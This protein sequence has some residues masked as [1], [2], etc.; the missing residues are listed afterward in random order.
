M[1]PPTPPNVLFIFPDQLRRYSAGYWSKPPF[2]PHV[3]GRPDPVVTPNIDLLAEQ[4]VVFTQAVANYPICSPY[5]GML[6]TGAYPATNG[7]W[8]NCFDGREHGLNT[9]V[10]CLPQIFKDAGYQTS[11][12][13]KCHWVKTEALFDQDHNYVGSTSEPGGHLPNRYDTY[14]PP[15]PSRIGIEY[16]FQTVRD[17]HF[18][19]ITYSSDPALVAGKKDGEAH[20]PHEYNVKLETNALLEYLDNS[21]GQ[22]DPDKPFFA[23]WSL[24]PPHNPWVDEHTDMEAYDRYYNRDEHPDLHKLLVRE[25]ADHEVGNY[26]RH[27]FAAVTSVDH[28]VGQVIA[29]LKELGQLENTI[30]VFTS[31][32]GEMLGSH[33]LT[34]KNVPYLESAA[35]PFIVHWPTQLKP[36]INDLILGTPDIMP[37]LLGLT[38]LA[39]RI[40][41]TVQGKNY[42]D[43][44][45]DCP[46]PAVEK[47]SSALYLHES[48]RGLLRE[49][50][51]L[52]FRTEAQFGSRVSAYLF[53]NRA[54]PYQQTKIYF[55]DKPLV[56]QALLKELAQKLKEAD[57]PWFR[58]KKHAHWIPYSSSTP[59]EKGFGHFRAPT[60]RTLS[61][62]VNALGLYF[63]RKTSSEGAKQRPDIDLPPLQGS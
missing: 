48:A 25:N 36:G 6:M 20:E 62:Q 38:G 30:L 46:T 21:R 4:G 2:A 15:G 28:Y 54:D 23:I 50:Y 29:K 13:G 26:A 59:S 19:P 47:P 17:D 53:D 33:K 24:N 31:D 37:T 63:K 40:P 1:N 60:G 39:E 32:H 43:L 12:F 44:I 49:D 11:Y 27:Y 58:E 16:F 61:A 51:T 35:I 55:Q 7:I 10:T 41:A 3:V 52:I 18:N 8:E 56:A 57:D 22:R 34:A 45:Q 9:D 14:V 5:R 42:A